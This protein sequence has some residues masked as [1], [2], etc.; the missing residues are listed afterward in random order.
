MV[1]CTSSVTLLFA[2]THFRSALPFSRAFACT[3]SPRRMKGIGSKLTTL[4]VVKKQTP[5]VPPTALRAVE[6]SAPP[7]K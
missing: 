5:A 4:K 1:A 6:M 2:K 7:F 3:P